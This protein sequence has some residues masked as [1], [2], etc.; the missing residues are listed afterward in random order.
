MSH[1][2]YNKEFTPDEVVE[3]LQSGDK[4]KI[5]SVIR[6]V[7]MWAPWEQTG[8]L[9]KKMREGANDFIG[10]TI[11]RMLIYGDYDSQYIEKKLM[12]IKLLLKH[13][14]KS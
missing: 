1:R 5:R 7:A 10:Y 8:E 12:P 9:E 13:L 11:Y 14:K 4:E 3:A 6:D 2:L